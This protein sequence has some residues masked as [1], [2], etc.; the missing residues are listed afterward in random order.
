MFAIRLLA[1]PSGR[2]RLFWSLQEAHQVSDTGSQE[3]E[4]PH[5][6]SAPTTSKSQ[7][8]GEQRLQ[9][10]T[11]HGSTGCP[12]GLR[13]PCQQGQPLGE[14]TGRVERP[15]VQPGSCLTS[16]PA[17]LRPPS[18]DFRAC[19]AASQ[20]QTVVGRQQPQP[21]GHSC[22]SCPFP[23]RTHTCLPSVVGLGSA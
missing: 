10:R 23:G 3:L 8:Q 7:H 6:V 19:L 2:T 4:V 17:L 21:P 16:G 14:Q 20:L 5:V 22:P 1:T 11:G 18:Q 9:G 12:S 13:R 15:G